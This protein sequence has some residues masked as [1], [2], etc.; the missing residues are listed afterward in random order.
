MME[1]RQGPDNLHDTPSA[2]MI[3]LFILE[4]PPTWTPPPQ[5]LD[6]GM[7]LEFHF[8]GEDSELVLSIARLGSLVMLFNV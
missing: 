7:H 2:K 1:V 4:G 3:A 5:R 8:P 6:S